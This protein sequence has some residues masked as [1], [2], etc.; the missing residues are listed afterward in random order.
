MACDLNVSIISITGDCSNTTNGAFIVEIDGDAPGFTYQ[1]VSPFNSTI[2]FTSSTLT[3]TGLSAGTY[4]FYV[5]DSCVPTNNQTEPINVYISSGTCVEILQTINTTCN[6]G[7]GS[8]TAFDNN[9]YGTV[10]FNLYEKQLGLVQQLFTPEIVSSQVTFQNLSPGTY[11]VVSN[12]GGGCTGK[13]ETCIVKSSTT[14]DFG[15]YVQNTTDCGVNT[16]SIYI[17][18]L[19]GVPP[20]VYLWTNGSSNSSITGLSEGLYSVTIQD[21]TGCITSSGVEITKVPNITITTFTATPPSCFGSDG[22]ITAFLTGGTAP[23]Y[24]SGSNGE[25]SITFANS[26][27]FTGLSSGF[28]EVKVTD[29]GL[30]NSSATT[31]LFTPNSFSVLSV[32]TNN[33]V[34][35]NSGGSIDI[36]LVGSSGEY[37]YSLTDSLGNTQSVIIGDTNYSF[38]NL[39]SGTYTLSIS[40]NG[41]CTYTQ[42]YTIN[43]VNL[44]SL[45]TSVVGT[46]C[47]NSDGSVTL[48]ITSGGTPPFFYQINNQSVTTSLLSYTFSGLSSGNYFAKV[49]D[50]NFC[51]Q[52]DNFLIPISS[53]VNFNLAGFGTSPG[54]NNGIIYSFLTSG[55]PPFSLNWSSNV[56]TGQT[57][58]SL[59]GLSAGTYSLTI[60][61][62]NGCTQSRD[63]TLYGFNVI[64][65][66]EL[67]NVSNTNLEFTGDLSKRGI[68]QY[69]ID[70]F[71]DLTSGDTGCLLEEALFEIEST[72]TGTTKSKIFY[73]GTTIFDYPSDNEMY[74]TIKDLVLEF[75][76]INNVIINPLD[77]TITIETIKNPPIGLFDAQ[78][79][80]SLKINYKINCVTCS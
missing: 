21:A 68:Q 41:I 44:F 28:F 14:L 76:G 63:I 7:N 38:A 79:T 35:N 34:C 17:T 18:G 45:S 6:I 64:S 56:P 72:L 57:G 58:Y 60:T 80:V 39:S 69:L 20:Y 32:T 77:N 5:T 37:T 52:T 78:L 55:E 16:G 8:I 3:F 66:Y 74:D 59:T 46:T 29:A 33:S 42:N 30:C 13:S 26:Y 70:G 12:D 9:N 4:S 23:Y 27:T 11:Y 48:T 71:F 50:A 40:N 75:L 24:F 2:P 67:F 53:S 73:T 54:E 62:D 31:S 22:Q 65:S 1:W 61:D 36:F 15:F 51:E 19:T 47:N 10:I 25:T 49:I 43:N